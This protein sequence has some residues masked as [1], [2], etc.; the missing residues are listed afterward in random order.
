MSSTEFAPVWGRFVRFIAEDDKVYGGEPEDPELDVGLALAAGEKVAVKILDSPSAI[1]EG[2]KFT[3]ETKTVKKL[4][5]PLSMSEAGTIRCVGMNYKDHVAELGGTIPQVPEIFMKASTSLHGPT[6]A[7]ILPKAAADAVDAEA[8]LTIVISKDCKDVDLSTALDYVLGYTLA[9]DVTARDVQSKILQWGYCKGFDTFCPL[10]PVL[11]SAKRLSNPSGL[12][13]KT[14][15][16][17]K[18]LQD[19][20]TANMIFSVA[21]IISYL[22]VGTTLPKGTVILTGTPSGIGHSFKP[23]LY[24]KEGTVLRI[25]CSHGIGTLCNTVVAEK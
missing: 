22:S 2:A 4:L 13:L 19:G 23:P 5:S 25:R 14:T 1:A 6:D 9:N 16:D 24:M 7:I 10:G 12:S 11:V 21:E 8:E 3:G 17:G 15:L 18:V 20:N